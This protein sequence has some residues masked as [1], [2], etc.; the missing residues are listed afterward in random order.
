MSKV[1]LPY[2]ES[3]LQGPFSTSFYTRLYNPPT[4]TPLCAVL[5]FAHGYLEHIGR[6]T[7]AHAK[8]ASR[9][10]AVF[11]Y[12]ERGFGRT[13]LD[14]EHKSPGSVYG[15]TG[16]M[17]ERMSDLEWAI[18]HARALFSGEVPL[19]LMGHSMAGG[20]VLSFATRTEAPPA[21]ETI[22]L[23]SGVIASSPLVRI[24]DNQPSPFI[25]FVL[26]ILAK[27]VPHM[28]LNTPIQDKV[29]SH[30]PTVGESA[31]KDPWIKPIGTTQG[32]ADM[33]HRGSLLLT[34]GYKSWPSNL[35]VLILHGTA[36][37]VNEYPQ[38]KQFAELLQAPDKK[39]VTYEDAM[40]DLM[41]EPAIKDQYF[42]ECVSWVKNHLP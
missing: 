5:V 28:S 32:V 10:I 40:H 6:Y 7:D 39:F 30:D 8:W 37:R 3:W 9:G 21:K 14:K 4:S 12:D 38:C 35:P 16:G 18:K 34:E 41:T 27:I 25:L 42:E 22:V 20:M 2:T 19:F 36:D 26:N 31:L 23:L 17:K 15:R 13:A 29:L 24:A 33:I 11:A 1:D